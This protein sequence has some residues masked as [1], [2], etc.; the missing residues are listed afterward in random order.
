MSRRMGALASNHPAGRATAADG[1]SGTAV[2]GP[3]PSC[4]PADAARSPLLPREAESVGRAPRLPLTLPRRGGRRGL[5]VPTGVARPERDSPPAP[6]PR[7]SCPLC[8]REARA[9]ATPAV[10]SGVRKASRD[11]WRLRLA[12]AGPSS[13]ENG[14]LVPRASGL[15]PDAPPSERLRSAGDEYA[16]LRG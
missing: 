2:G 11:R 4:A 14:S 15:E 1:T 5:A 8:L 13:S 6:P 16:P 12:A 9:A 10:P 3:A 7:S